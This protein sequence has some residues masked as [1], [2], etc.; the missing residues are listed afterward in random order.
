MS[1]FVVREILVGVC[2][3]VGFVLILVL[4]RLLFGKGLL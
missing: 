2:R 3:A 1:Q 4:V